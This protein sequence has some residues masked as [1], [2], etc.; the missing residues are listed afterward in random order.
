MERMGVGGVG[1]GRLQG[2]MEKKEGRGWR[3]SLKLFN[4]KTD[5][6]PF[7]G[8]R[9]RRRI[10][11]W[12]GCMKQ[13]KGAFFCGRFLVSLKPKTLCGHSCRLSAELFQMCQ[14]EDVNELAHLSPDAQDGGGDGGVRRGGDNSRSVFAA[15][16][17]SLSSTSLE[18]YR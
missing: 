9:P 4:V 2:L 15:A 17:L 7:G 14:P 5:V 16:P 8:L 18:N 10:N 1:L 6:G 13:S 3:G 12:V 11:I